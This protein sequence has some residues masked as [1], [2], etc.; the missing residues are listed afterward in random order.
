[1]PGNNMINSIVKWWNDEDNLHVDTATAIKN[2]SIWDKADVLANYHL[3]VLEDNTQQGPYADVLK[4]IALGLVGSDTVMNPTPDEP[5]GRK[6][7]TCVDT[8]CKVFKHAGLTK[9]LPQANG[10]VSSNNNFSIDYMTK[11]DD[12]QRVT[13]TGDDNVKRWDTSNITT[14]DWVIVNN[15]D[16]SKH[17]MLAVGTT[18]DAVIAVHDPG[19]RYDIDIKHYPKYWFNERIAGIFRLQP[20]SQ[21][22]VDEV[23]NSEM[24]F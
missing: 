6:S 21:S 5:E 13:H 15:E 12:W 22:M 14:G 20:S 19:S 23:L 24:K 9:F 10:V 18:E 2:Q 16:G 3:Q 8:V 7:D 1:M 11:S 4:N 17:S